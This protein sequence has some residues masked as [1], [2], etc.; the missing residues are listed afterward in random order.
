MLFY[1][2]I[3]LVGLLVVWWIVAP[4]G[5]SAKH[6]E[7]APELVIYL[8]FKPGQELILSPGERRTIRL[9]DMA[10]IVVNAPL[11]QDVYFGISDEGFNIFGVFPKGW[12]GCAD[13]ECIISADDYI[14]DKRDAPFVAFW[15]LCR[16]KLYDDPEFLQAR[17]ETIPKDSTMLKL[18]TPIPDEFL[19][20]FKGL[21]QKTDAGWTVDLRLVPYYTAYFEFPPKFRE[22]LVFFYSQ[23]V[24]YDRDSALAGKPPYVCSGM[25][26]S[27]GVETLMDIPN[28]EYSL[29]VGKR[30][31]LLVW[32]DYDSVLGVPVDGITRDIS[33]MVMFWSDAPIE[34]DLYIRNAGTEVPPYFQ[35]IIPKGWRCGDPII[36]TLRYPAEL[37]A[38][39]LF[40]HSPFLLYRFKYFS[41]PQMTVP[42][43]KDAADGVLSCNIASLVPGT[44][45]AEL[46]LSGLE[47]PLQ[48]KAG[49]C[50]YN[51]HF[52]LTRPLPCDVTVKFNAETLIPELN[53]DIQRIALP[54]DTAVIPAGGV[55]GVLS[56]MLTT[57]PLPVRPEIALLEPVSVLCRAPIHDPDVD[58][59]DCCVMLPAD[60]EPFIAYVNPC[61]AD[62]PLRDPVVSWGC[63][64]YFDVYAGESAGLH[65]VI[66]VNDLRDDIRKYRMEHWLFLMVRCSGDAVYGVDYTYRFP[67]DA[68]ETVLFDGAIEF[69]QPTLGVTFDVVSLRP[70]ETPKTLILTLASA[71]DDLIIGMPDSI[72]IIFGAKK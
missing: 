31:P 5:K 46:I 40:A 39:R 72:E 35:A 14:A 57:D 43:F 10:D 34:R 51:F 49:T 68:G 63:D 22:Q 18:R 12:N 38:E 56:V 69:R 53:G 19:P 50:S 6:D 29:D 4:H 32:C 59:D 20:L 11:S 65:F 16:V 33:D 9:Q 58:A 25:V 8:D 55:R 54:V 24:V 30:F 37:G 67:E 15:W 47:R 48:T 7:V 36:A 44:Q 41:D 45:W 26:S 21:T 60:Y 70:Q 62:R 17:G 64:F 27:D 23:I 3:I 61:D 13:I 52:Y 2:A 71:E 28:V 1:I 66:D 42:Y